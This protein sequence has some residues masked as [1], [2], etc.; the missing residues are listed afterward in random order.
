MAPAGT[1]NVALNKIVTSSD[2]EPIIGEL[3]M[4]TDSDKSGSEGSFVELGP[5]AQHVTIDLGAKFHIYA[6]VIWHYHNQARV[7]SDV[8][9]QT[10]DN[11]DF[12][13]N[14]KILFNNDHDNSSELGEG[15]DKHYVE[16][17]EGKL[18]DAKG[19]TSRYVRLYSNGNSSNDLNHYVE[20]EVYG[21]PAI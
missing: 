3:A 15:K 4:I 10:A 2:T 17:Y 7:Y 12:T 21:K 16:T 8:I 6:I 20:V 9:V 18:I 1:E 19:D 5:F 14:I 13:K 11:P